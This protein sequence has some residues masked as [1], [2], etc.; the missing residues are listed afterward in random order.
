MKKL[1][2]SI[3]SIFALFLTSC[4]YTLDV[5]KNNVHWTSDNN[6]IEFSIEGLNRD[7]GYGTLK[8]DN[9]VI[10][11]VVGFFYLGARELYVWSKEALDESYK[12]GNTN[13]CLISFTM[14]SARKQHA[15]GEL[16]RLTLTTAMNETGISEYNR[17]EF[18]IYRSDLPIEQ[19]DAKNHFGVIW[20]N[21]EFN[22]SLESTIDA[23]FTRKIYGTL[24]VNEETK[25]IY[26]S[27]LDNRLF[28]VYVVEDDTETLVLS[29][30]YTTQLRELT[31]L[32]E[33]NSIFDEITQLTLSSLDY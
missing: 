19:Y 27:F 17:L 23:Y 7:L 5:Y 21:T 8:L 20:S 14:D 32:L 9:E 12:Q 29:G 28:E 18:D 22:I 15:G 6:I 3:I 30:S 1:L 4:D 26:L 31:L 24:I 25:S 13:V 11:I 16:D 2:V 10:D 33:Y